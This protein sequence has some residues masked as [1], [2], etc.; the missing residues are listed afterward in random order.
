MR[1]TI[2]LIRG[3][4]QSGKDF[5]GKALCQRYGYQ[6]FAFADSLKRMVCSLYRCPMDI[7]HSQDGKKQICPS[8]EQ[9]RTYRQILI[10]EALRLRALDD[11]LFVRECCEEI[12]K[13]DATKVVITDWRY[14][15][16]FTL[17]GELFPDATIV[18]LHI[19]RKDT[20]VSPVN[21]ISEHHLK[22][23]VGDPVLVNTMDD[24]VYQDIHRFMETI[25]EAHKKS[26]N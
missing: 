16:E 5:V 19:I 18:P 22:E 17:L 8:D 11:T 13:L 26:V 2:I 3:Y 15:V 14:P 1:R 12:K 6:R 4:S 25:Q 23:R 10:D 7:L 24:S 21:D 9:G 20:L